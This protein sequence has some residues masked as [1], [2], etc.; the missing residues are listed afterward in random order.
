[1]NAH[2]TSPKHGK[3]GPPSKKPK[4]KEKMKKKMKKKDKRSSVKRS[5]VEKKSSQFFFDL[6]LYCK[7]FHTKIKSILLENQVYIEKKIDLILYGGFF[8]IFYYCCILYLLVR[9]FRALCLSNLPEF[10]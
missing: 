6:I 9:L 3:K 4:K 10:G 2:T 8:I 7:I 1:L 5:T